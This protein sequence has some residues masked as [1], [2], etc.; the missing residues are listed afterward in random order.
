MIVARFEFKPE[1]ADSFIENA[2]AGQTVTEVI[3]E[4][5][6]GLIDATREF[7]NCLLDCTAIVGD[8]VVALSSFKA[9]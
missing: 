3:F 8:K 2:A 5:V 4:S 9:K 7:E 1:H 6:E